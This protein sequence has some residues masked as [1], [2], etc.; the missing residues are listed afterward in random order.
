MA[1]Y[2]DIWNGIK[3]AANFV[4]DVFS[5]GEKVIKTVAPILP[6]IL[7]KGGKVSEFKDTPA[8]RRKILN[9]FNRVHKTKIT[10]KQLEK[11]M[12]KKKMMKK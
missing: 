11:H 7:K 8:N 6:L 2:D 5:T 9:A 10:M 3:S 12:L 1:W 4:G